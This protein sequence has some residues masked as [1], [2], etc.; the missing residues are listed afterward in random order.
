MELNLDPWSLDYDIQQA[1]DDE[2]YEK[3]NLLLDLR[4]KLFGVD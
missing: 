4:K 1:Y 2:D 3:L